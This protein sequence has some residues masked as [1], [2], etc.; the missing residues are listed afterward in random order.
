MN[1]KDFR[2][3][4]WERLRKDYWMMFLATLIVMAVTVATAP[5]V[6]ITLL[7]MGPLT[8]G[9]NIF[10]VNVA[11]GNSPRLEDLMTPF[12]EKFVNS[13]SATILKNVFIALW[14]F[15]L[16]IPG[17]IKSYSYAMTEYIVAFNDDIGGTDAITKSREMMDGH[18]FRLFKLHFSFIGW[19][20]LGIL[21]FGV[22]LIFIAPYI[23]A[24]EAEFY[25]DLVG[26]SPTVENV[27]IEEDEYEI[28]FK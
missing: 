28:E 7:L 18:K 5:T 26:E 23:K 17:I 15:L 24:A 10:F 16:I 1:S 2:N 25:L 12:T 3:K 13:L 14:T 21:T 22:G 11:R 8:V 4:A 19:I 6:I 9:L 20:I 27:V